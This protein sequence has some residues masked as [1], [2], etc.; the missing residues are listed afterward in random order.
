LR[1]RLG[2]SAI[3]QSPAQQRVEIGGDARKSL[4]HPLKQL[5]IVRLRRHV[6]REVGARALWAGVAS[7]RGVSPN[8]GAA[9]DDGF[10]E[11]S[12]SGLDVSTGDCGEVEL[13]APRQI[14]LRRQ[15]IAM[16]ET[17]GRDIGCDRIGYG[18]IFGAIAAL[19]DRRPGLHGAAGVPW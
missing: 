5:R 1:P 13:E 12:L 18:E 3:R 17:P 6:H 4:P 11:T 15:A 10:D 9:P 7:N 2:P 19:Q 14:S 16:G 8:K